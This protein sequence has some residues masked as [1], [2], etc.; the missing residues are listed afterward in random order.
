M[1]TN[2]LFQIIVRHTREVLPE[3]Q[4]H[5]IHLEDRLV[6]LGANSIDRAEIIMMTM[7]TLSLQ[8]PRIELFGVQNIGEL[9]EV[10]Y[11]K[12]QTY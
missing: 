12:L 11:A 8:I 10:L 6:D 7:D 3:L 4:D 1:T 2:E 5:P 9:A